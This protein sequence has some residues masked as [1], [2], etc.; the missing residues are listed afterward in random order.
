MPIY[1]FECPECREAFD[2]LVRSAAAVK[3]VTCPACGSR[4]VKKKLSA[5]AAH[6]GGGSAAAAAAGAACAPGGT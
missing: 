4:K 1:E 6:I 3:D 2:E 5:V